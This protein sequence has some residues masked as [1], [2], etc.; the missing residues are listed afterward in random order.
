MRTLPI[1]PAASFLRSPAKY[2]NLAVL[3]ILCALSACG[4]PAEDVAA[5]PG[6]TA[7]RMLLLVESA[8]TSADKGRCVLAVSARNDT[9]AAA[10]NIQAAWTARTDGF[11][12]ISD[13]Q[14]LGDFAAGEARSV[15][16][17]VFGAPCEA[18]Q[19]LKLTR[20]VCTVGPADDPPR[21]CADLVMLDARGLGT[22]RSSP[23]VPR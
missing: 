14:F 21:S 10:L 8:E 22:M 1:E 15:Q 4:T 17:G 12:S 20:A 7:G 3:P 5:S 6:D 16:L 9:G 18:V 19:E 11:G 2:H 23:H 13:Y